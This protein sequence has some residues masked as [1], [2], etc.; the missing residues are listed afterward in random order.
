MKQFAASLIIFAF[1][2]SLI[3]CKQ[4]RPAPDNR[5]VRIQQLEKQVSDLSGD[6][7]SLH[8]QISMLQ[9][10]VSQMQATQTRAAAAAASSSRSEMN[11]ER[12]KQE[13]GPLLVDAI[14]KVK[15]ETDTAKKGSQ[16]GMRTEYD[17]KRAV[18]GLVR[19]DNPEV[20]YFA[21]VIV[22]YQK[23]LE[24]SKESKQMSSGTTRFLFAYRKGRWTFEKV[25]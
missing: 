15:K 12:V 17:P 16:F 4:E 6:I 24:S 8:N 11:V 9:E 1:L 7:Q 18:Y 19:S 25:E 5:D 22:S 13:V 10:Q 2:F 20:P 14:E 3:A 23:F 21:R